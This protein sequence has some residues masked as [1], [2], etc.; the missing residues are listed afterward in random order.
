MYNILQCY[1]SNKTHKI[2][3]VVPSEYDISSRDW[4]EWSIS[5]NCN[6][7]IE[8]NEV[9]DFEYDFTGGYIKDIRA[10]L[11]NYTVADL[12]VTVYSNSCASFG[13]NKY[14]ETEQIIELIKQKRAEYSTNKA[15]AMEENITLLE[16]LD[17][18]STRGD[19]AIINKKN[20][21]YKVLESELKDLTAEYCGEVYDVIVYEHGQAVDSIGGLYLNNYGTTHEIAGL[22]DDL[23]PDELEEY[24]PTFTQLI[25]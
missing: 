21:D 17:E 13:F 9:K 16:V 3:T 6:R 19:F 4:S 18:L 15:E 8:I 11:Q 22:F 2:Y 12:Y 10:Y 5:I 14:I 25:N 24:E 23:D 7:Y 20:A 1:K